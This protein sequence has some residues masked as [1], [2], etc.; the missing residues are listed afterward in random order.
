MRS[1]AVRIDTHTKIPPHFSVQFDQRINLLILSLIHLN[2]VLHGHL[3]IVI[4][5]LEFI[6][7]NVQFLNALK[8]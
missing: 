7:L 8:V 2:E 3:H 5:I 6:N 4:F 1:T